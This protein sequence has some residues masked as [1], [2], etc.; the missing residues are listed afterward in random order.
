MNTKKPEKPLPALHAFPATKK[1]SWPG[2]APPSSSVE[3][4]QKPLL[5][6]TL[7]ACVPTKTLGTHGTHGVFIH[8][9]PMTVSVR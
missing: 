9:N 1:S 7:T 6:L 3:A 5:S 2:P 4:P 8:A